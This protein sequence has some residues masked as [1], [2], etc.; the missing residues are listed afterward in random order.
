MPRP[1]LDLPIAGLLNL[2]HCRF[3]AK[4]SNFAKFL[5]T[6]QLAELGPGPR[7]GVQTEASLERQLEA[8]LEDSALS[9]QRQELVRALILLWHD[10]L[11]PAHTL[12]QNIEGPD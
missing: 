6:D 7:L 5:E 8:L 3:M 9:R 1:A 12:A 2:W 4:S 11:D 10:H